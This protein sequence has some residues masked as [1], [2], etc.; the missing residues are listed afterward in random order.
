[1]HQGPLLV[2]RRIALLAKA[3]RL[4]AFDSNP[5]TRRSVAFWANDGHRRARHGSHLLKDATFRSGAVSALFDVPLDQ[6][7]PFDGHPVR[8][9][10]DLEDFA[11]LA[12]L[13]F[14]RALSA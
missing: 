8:R 14:E 1:M 10:I 9:A 5:D 11:A 12:G 6:P 7:N 13:T 3:D 2:N 4:F